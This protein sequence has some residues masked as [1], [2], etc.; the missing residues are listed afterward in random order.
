ML[1]LRALQCNKILRATTLK[2]KKKKTK[3]NKTEKEKKKQ[4]E[5]SETIFRAGHRIGTERRKAER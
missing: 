4:G 3:R 1:Q 2:K 5:P